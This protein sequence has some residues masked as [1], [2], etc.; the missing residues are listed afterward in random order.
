MVRRCRRSTTTEYAP[1][2]LQPQLAEQ[3]PARHS[4]HQGQRGLPRIQRCMQQGG[5]SVCVHQSPRRRAVRM[6][7]GHVGNEARFEVLSIGFHPIAYQAFG[8]P[9]S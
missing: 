9:G 1:D 2:R 8:A 4:D 3:P 7:H 6:A 5:K